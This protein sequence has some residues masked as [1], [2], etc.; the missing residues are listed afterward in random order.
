MNRELLCHLLAKRAGETITQEL[1]GA[2]VREAFPDKS[3]DLSQFQPAQCGRLVFH[4]ER[5]A[6]IVAELHPL[7]ELQWLETEKYRHGQG[8]NLDYAYFIE[9]E[10]DGRLL[11]FTARAAGRLVGNMRMYLY[12]DLHT[13]H[14]AAKEDTMYLMPDYRA[15]RNSLRFLQYLERG[16]QTAG[17]RQITTDSKVSNPSV[18][19]LNEYMGFA[20][21]ANQYVKF[22][23]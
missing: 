4:V 2:L 10:H 7:H 16:L 22:F 19:R 18:A 20:L 6:G 5:L 23:E 14:L 15:G 11:Q 9:A 17:V 3:I 1:A 12:R 13:G 21:V 8:L